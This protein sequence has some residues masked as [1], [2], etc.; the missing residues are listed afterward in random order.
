MAGCIPLTCAKQHSKRVCVAHA[1]PV[2]GNSTAAVHSKQQHRSRA[3]VAQA[4]AQRRGK[5]AAT[6]NQHQQNHASMPVA[7]GRQSSSR[8]IG[9]ASAP[10]KN[11]HSSMFVASARQYRT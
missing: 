8:H 2:I 9:A 11:Q 10:N 6:H 3:F 5:T 1:V 7:H 4:M